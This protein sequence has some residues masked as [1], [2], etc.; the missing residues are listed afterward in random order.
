MI[1]AK[2]NGIPCEVKEGT[3]ILE[4]ARQIY[5]EI[6]VL[7]KHPDLAPTAACGIC[8][9]K[10]KGTN[11]M[12]RACCTPIDE[13]MEIITHD[14]EIIEVRR[15]VV[16]LIMSNHPNECL[17]CGRNQHCELQDLCG[18]FGIRDNAFENTVSKEVI[19]DTNRALV[20]DPR[21]CITC[22][23][24][25][26]V[27][28]EMQN[29]HALC[30]IERGYKTVIT[31]AGVS[32]S[33]SPCVKCGQCSAHC[34][35]GAIV[36]YDETGK[37]WDLVKAEDLHTCVQIAPAV[38]VAIGEAFGYEPGANLT[39]KL[40]AALRRMGFDAIFDTNFGADVTI[41]EEASEFV[42]RFRDG[43]DELPLISSCCPAWVD[44]MERYHNDMI[45]YFSTCKS[46]HEMLGV[47]AKT[48]YAK[49]QGLDPMKIRMISV[50]PC[51]AKKWEIRR[52]VEMS[53]SGYQ[54]VDV[55]ITTR[56][57][58]RMIKQAGIDFK[59]LPDEECD[60]L[61][62][63]YS[64]AGTIFGATGGVM[65]AALRTAQ[66]LLTGE[67]L[68]TVEFKQIR[69]LAGVREAELEIAGKP[70]RI[71]VAHGLANVESVLD[72]VR[73]A[74]EAGE[75]TPYHFIEVMAC[76]GG[77]VGGGGQP[78]GITDEQ[79][80]KRAAGLYSEDEKLKHRKSKDNP[81]VKKL[82]DDFLGEPL[83]E[84]SHRL[85]HTNYQPRATYAR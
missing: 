46:P 13:G 34:P 41:M 17:T 47:L 22:G 52:S 77:C 85:L 37:V 76:P 48:Y 78:Y 19:L 83:S 68:Q 33:E 7:C 23:R 10:A 26:Q 59:H 14:P 16:E 64:G 70:L 4:A 39:G 67:E 8:I 18:N 43:G 51:T 44:F 56:E 32:L 50:M 61:L 49:Q 29:V 40:Y 28:Q 35:T 2:I 73:T 72:K 21:K 6:P 82:Y 15:S 84:K 42:S 1:H 75:A 57:L 12:L 69:G 38:R 74:K 58:A 11:K 80:K 60:Q 79:R 30:F 27:C 71:A 54:D 25:V 5:I 65:E 20:F 55:S 66:D 81:H 9:V 31:S 62:G 24:C 53:A 45:E 36:E 63:G 3:T